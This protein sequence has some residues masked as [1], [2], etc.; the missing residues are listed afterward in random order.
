MAA[1]VV[2]VWLVHFVLVDFV[3]V[4]IV[5]LV[6][7]A[8]PPRGIFRPVWASYSFLLQL[9]LSSPSSSSGGRF[10]IG[11]NCFCRVSVMNIE[12][13]AM[14]NPVVGYRCFQNK[15]PC[16]ALVPFINSYSPHPKFQ[17]CCD[18]G[19]CITFQKWAFILKMFAPLN[20]KWWQ[21]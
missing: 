5:D 17:C 12:T 9:S 15:R 4:F 18:I 7:I 10:R 6:L 2:I 8:S 19:A 21:H 3:P 1:A 11:H 16:M 13:V 20:S 14:L